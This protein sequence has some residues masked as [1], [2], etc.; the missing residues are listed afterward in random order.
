MIAGYD[1]LEYYNDIG[2]PIRIRQEI[3]RLNEKE[4]RFWRKVR[5]KETSFHPKILEQHKRFS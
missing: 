2:L 4:R 3:E 5:K 1:K